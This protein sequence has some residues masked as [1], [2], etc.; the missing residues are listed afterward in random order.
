[1]KIRVMACAVLMIGIAVGVNAQQGRS[2]REILQRSAASVDGREIVTAVHICRGSVSEASHTH[3]GDLSGYVLE[4][5]LTL[6]RQ[7]IPD[8]TLTAGQT[9]FVAAGIRHHMVS[10][11][12][13]RLVATYFVEKDKPLAVGAN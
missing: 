10:A 4:G 12:D 1:M 2:S 9:F 11:G 3:P 13:A 7:G 5:T 8:L 6:V